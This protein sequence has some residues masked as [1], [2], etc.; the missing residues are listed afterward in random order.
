MSEK[1][2]PCPRCGGAGSISE[3]HRCDLEGLVIALH[4]G[5]K[6]KCGAEAPDCPRCDGTGFNGD[7]LSA[8]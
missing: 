1:Y 5:D 6:C 8:R 3:A 2:G 4:P 7:A